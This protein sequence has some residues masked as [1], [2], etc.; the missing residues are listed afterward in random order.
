MLRQKLLNLAFY[1][2]D[3]TFVH[4]FPIDQ[5]SYFISVAFCQRNAAGVTVQPLRCSDA[6]K[7]G[8]LETASCD[9]QLVMKL[10][11]IGIQPALT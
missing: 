8:T 5:V 10:R 1:E 9:F 2:A 6:G 7:L 3:L 4:P 11:L